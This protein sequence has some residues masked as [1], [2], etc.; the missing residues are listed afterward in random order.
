[1]ITRPEGN[2]LLLISQ[3]AHA[4]LAGKLA[5]AWG[6]G[7]FVRPWPFEAVILATRLHDIGWLP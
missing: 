5:A 6:N 1:M 3:P 4:W 2:G 7:D